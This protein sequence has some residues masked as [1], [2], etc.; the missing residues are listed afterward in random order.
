[1][2][3]GN[4]NYLP[5]FLA[6]KNFIKNIIPKLKKEITNFKFCIIG[7]INKTRKRLLTSNSNVEILGSIK[8]LKNYVK[9]AFCG[10]ANLEI[11]TG[12]QGKVFTYMSHGLPVICSNKVSKNFGK[13]VLSYDRI[14]K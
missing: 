2:F 9:T 13:S 10:I 14:M 8:N 1:M 7:D 4:L 5:N 11:A 6:C 12:V 3:V